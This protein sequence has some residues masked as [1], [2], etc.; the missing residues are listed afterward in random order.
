MNNAVILM[1]TYNERENITQL[2][3]EIFA[4]HPDIRILVIDDNSPD[5]T[6]SAVVELARIYPN[7][8]LLAREKKE[9]LGAAYK[10]GIL[11]AYSFP[12]IQKVITMDADGS[13]AAE[14]LADLLSASTEHMLVIGS[15]YVK[16]GA[17]ENWE[18]WRYA[19]SRYGNLYSRTITGLPIRDLT[20]GFMCIDVDVLKKIDFAN[21]HASGYAF[22]M[23]LKFFI[24]HTLRGSV[25]EVPIIF[26]SRREGESKISRHIV[27]EGLKTPWRLLGRRFLPRPHVETYHG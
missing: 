11:H 25:A 2:V 23:E 12:A 21:V 15:R 5:G 24:V 10:A 1:P 16:G 13:H 14:Y 26:K 7:L 27:R 20:A 8:S 18:P 19:L 4:A 3:P 22:L 17:I 6:G 9:G